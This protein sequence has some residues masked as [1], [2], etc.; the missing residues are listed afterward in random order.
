MIVFSEKKTH[1]NDLFI[2]KATL[3]KNIKEKKFIKHDQLTFNE[4]PLYIYH[5]DY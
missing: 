4:K 1:A 5:E 2:S 3:Q